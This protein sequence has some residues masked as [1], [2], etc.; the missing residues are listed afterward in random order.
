VIRRLTGMT[1]AEFIAAVDDSAPPL[2]QEQRTRL[3][4]LL[5]REPGF[6][7]PDVPARPTP[8]LDLMEVSP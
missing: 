4:A 7:Q 1:D 5:G 8:A 2:T 6:L 3:A